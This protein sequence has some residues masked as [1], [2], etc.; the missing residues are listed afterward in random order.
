[1]PVVDAL[2][3]PQPAEVYL[4]SSPSAGEIYQTPTQIPHKNP[5]AGYFLQVF[6]K[7]LGQAVHRI[8]NDMSVSALFRES[9]GTTR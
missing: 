2:F 7:L 9:I 8:H 1:M 6:L 3:A 4:P 5:P